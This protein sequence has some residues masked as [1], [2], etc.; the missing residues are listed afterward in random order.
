MKISRITVAVA[1]TALLFSCTK[2]NLRKTPKVNLTFDVVNELSASKA[3]LNDKAVEFAAGDKIGVW[4]GTSM[5]CFET[6][7][8]GANASFSGTAADAVSYILISPFSENYSVNGSVVTYSIPEIQ[9]ATPGSA[10]PNALVSMAKVIGTTGEAVLYNCVG[11]LKVV[12]PDGLT[13]RKSISAAD[14]TL[15][16]ESA[17]HSRSIPMSRHWTMSM[18]TA[19]ARA[20]RWFLRPGRA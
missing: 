20:L 7:A 8:G 18:K 3:V 2:E 9:V 16:L 12:V 1:C 19:C 10:D 14:Q 17:D 6:V 15:Q 4:D 13:V 5:N 11:L